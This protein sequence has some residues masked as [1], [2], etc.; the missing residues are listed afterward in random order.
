MQKNFPKIST[1]KKTDKFGIEIDE[2][3]N[4]VNLISSCNNLKLIGINIA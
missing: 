2:I 4:I 3:E 1:G